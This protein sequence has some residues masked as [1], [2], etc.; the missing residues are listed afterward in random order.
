QQFGVDEAQHGAK[1][2]V[3]QLLALRPVWRCP[4]SPAER[5][6]ERWCD[7]GA[8]GSGALFLVGLALVEDAKE[9]DPGELGHVLEGTRAVRAP[10]DVADR[11]DGGVD[12][13][14]RRQALAVTL[15]VSLPSS[16]GLPD[17]DARPRR[18]SE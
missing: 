10:H 1:R 3:L 18:S 7:L 4:V 8:N 12:R 11:L 17:S 5:R 16:H 2:A 9:Q 15:G 6:L 14:R 13:L